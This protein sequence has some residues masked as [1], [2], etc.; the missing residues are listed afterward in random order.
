[1][2]KNDEDS[3]PKLLTRGETAEKLGLGI[4]ISKIAD[5]RG[6]FLS[7]QTLFCGDVLFG[8]QQLDLQGSILYKCIMYKTPKRCESVF[9]VD[10]TYLDDSRIHIELPNVDLTDRTLAYMNLSEAN[11][12]FLNLSYSN[13]IGANLSNANLTG[14][15]LTGVNLTDVN[16]KGANLKQ[17]YIIQ[18]NLYRADLTD[19]NLQ[20]SE[21]S[22]S[23]LL[24]AKLDSKN[25]R[26][27]RFYNC[28]IDRSQKRFFTEEQ[29]SCLRCLE[30]SADLLYINLRGLDLIDVDLSKAKL[31][32]STL[33]GSNLTRANLEASDLYR[34]DLSDAN[35]TNAN[36]TRAH[37]FG[38]NLSGANLTGAILKRTNLSGANLTNTNLTDVDLHGVKY[39]DQTIGLSD[40]QKAKMIFFE[41]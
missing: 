26:E 32:Y 34:S 13:S 23:V 22:H 31:S 6:I 37:L 17:A 11:L 41:N 28:V 10:C 2:R 29:N 12:M 14:A 21:F 7:N 35:L 33:S 8:E 5:A 3:T 40:E 1:M 9:L 20:F 39:N 16:L 25:I 15:C 27:A 18:S 24:N 36:L 4:D 38:A 19:A 30:P